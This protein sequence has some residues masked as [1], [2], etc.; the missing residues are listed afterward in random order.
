M[1][2][3]ERKLVNPT[4]RDLEVKIPEMTISFAESVV[5]DS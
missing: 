2:L 3:R 1:E 5:G 4:N